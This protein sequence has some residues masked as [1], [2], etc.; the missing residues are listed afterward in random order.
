MVFKAMRIVFILTAILM[1]TNINAQKIVEWNG[2]YQLQ[3]SDFKSPATQIGEGSVYSVYTGS[4][5]DFS[6]YMSNAEFVFT[7]NFNSRVN[8]TF[9]RDAAS[10]V[11]PDSLTALNLL[12]FSRYDFDLSELYARKFRKKLYEGKRAFSSLSFFQPIYDEIQQELVE[13]H[14]QAANQTD[15]GA[16]RE[17]LGELHLEVSREIDALADF[18]KSCKPGKKKK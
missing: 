10:L 5:M 1:A 3:L 9:N 13:R 15:V 18:C 2:I 11:A 6:F 8:C 17:K 14:T 12:Q 7:K 4:R 16:N